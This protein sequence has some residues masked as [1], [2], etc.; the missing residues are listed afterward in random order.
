VAEQSAPQP[1]AP[2][3][4]S[5]N[6]A[7]AHMV[8]T[9]LPH[10]VLH[11]RLF[12]RMGFF[13]CGGAWGLRDQL[14]DVSALIQSHPE[15]TRLQIFRCA[16][17]QF[18]EGDALHWWHRIPGLGVRGVRTRYADDYLWLPFVCAE[19]VEKTGDSAILETPLPFR[20]GEE[21]RE[22]ES[23]RY[24]VYPRSAERASLYEHCLRAVRRALRFGPRGLPLMCGGDWNDGMNVIGQNE[25]GESVWMGQFLVMVL[26]KTAGL[27]RLQN[28][29]DPAREFLAHAARL[30][31]AIDEHCWEHDHYL[32]AFW[33]D[34]TPLGSHSSPAAQ[35]D[36]LT[37]SFA[38]LCRM[39]DPARRNA[40]LSAALERLGAPDHNLVR[41]LAEPFAP[42]AKR[43]GYI[44][45]YPP[46]VRENGGQY[47]HAAMWLCLALRR[48]GRE[49]EAWR[50]FNALNPAQS[51]QN[52]AH[53]ARYRAE[54]YALAG[55][56]CAA[57]GQEGRAGW[58]HYTGAAAWALRFCRGG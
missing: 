58:S 14:Q 34:G 32:R 2:L 3:F 19:Y 20:Q 35:I 24:A 16:A 38:V 49:E 46:G 52:P 12:G 29:G 22:D 18:P 57:P 17:A 1:R 37:Q 9:W 55:D 11:S 54:P 56:V 50:W 51:C 41:L 44:N 33:D 7:L 13:Q 28:D 10:Q 8:N 48:E 43:A 26:E 25:R 23:E 39:P 6:K 42:G 53:M 15:L 36:S 47:T 21:L 27:C 5:Q 4:V 31:Q 40:A 30:R 45:A